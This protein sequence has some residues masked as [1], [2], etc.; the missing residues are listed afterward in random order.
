MDL[1]TVIIF[2]AGSYIA[3]Q[4][5]KKIKYNRLICISSS[6]NKNNKKI[7]KTIKLK[8]LIIL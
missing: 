6:L 1:D 7:T 4:I 5:V 3:K 8:Y 2:G